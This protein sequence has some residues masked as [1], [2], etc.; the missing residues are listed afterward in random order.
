MT[1]L[2]IALAIVMVMS[3]FLCFFGRKMHVLMNVIWGAGVSLIYLI[4]K[5][6]F[7]YRS[8]IY[9][10]LVTAV[11]LLASVV[12]RRIGCFIMAA[13]CGAAAGYMAGRLAGMQYGESAY[14]G[15]LICV[16]ILFAVA[17]VIWPETMAAVGSA[18]FGAGMITHTALFAFDVLRGYV[19]I[20]GGSLE[21]K[22]TGIAQLF[23][24]MGSSG[25]MLTAFIAMSVVLFVCGAVSQL[26][27]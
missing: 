18:A 16:S 12:R 23:S 8:F 7:N 2:L 1:A 14:K 15:V 22:I 9:A 3:I 24:G 27:K 20:P 21:N 26:K 6:G 11:V 25:R 17:G 10:G 13:A 4:G 5:V 19:S